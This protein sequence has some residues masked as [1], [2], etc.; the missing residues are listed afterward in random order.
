V[1]A[2]AHT[3]LYVDLPML[4][5][6]IIIHEFEEEKEVV[7]DCWTMDDQGSVDNSVGHLVQYSCL[8]LVV[9]YSIIR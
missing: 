9:Q 2:I 5:N 8:L 3:L 7:V 4:P 6:N 1:S